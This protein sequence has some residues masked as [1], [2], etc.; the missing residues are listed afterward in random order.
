[1]SERD[2][3]VRAGVLRP[4]RGIVRLRQ[5]DNGQAIAARKVELQSPATKRALEILA[6][7]G[8]LR[9]R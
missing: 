9:M 1:M 2:E 3:L 7:A 8:K 6:A 4:N 5:R